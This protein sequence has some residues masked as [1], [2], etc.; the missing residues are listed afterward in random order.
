MRALHILCMG[1]ASARALLKFGRVCVESN[2]NLNAATFAHIPLINLNGVT[3][4]QSHIQND[5]QHI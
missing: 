2:K 3:R 1:H 4:L 5:M